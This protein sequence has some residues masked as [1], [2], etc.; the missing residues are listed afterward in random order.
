MYRETTSFC[1]RCNTALTVI[2]GSSAYVGTTHIEC[3][4]CGTINKTNDKPYSHLSFGQKIWGFIR[5]F[6]FDIFFILPL[7]LI[8]GTF[9]SKTEPNTFIGI[10]GIFFI[11]YNGYKVF[12]LIDVIPKIEKEQKRIDDLINKI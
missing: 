1:G 4:T 8:I 11:G 5:T 12:T 6:V 3:K 9:F 10:V 2:V 7:F